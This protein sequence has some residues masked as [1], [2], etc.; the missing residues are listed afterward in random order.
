[1]SRDLRALF[2]PRSLA[3]VGASADPTKWGNVLARGALAGA[4]RRPVYLV[5]RSGGEILGQRAL[6]SLDDVPEPPELVVVSVPT[7][8][9]EDAVDAALAAGARAIVVV[10]AGLGETGADAKAREHA[11]VERVRAAGAVMLGPNC[12]GVFDAAQELDLGWSELP[13]GPIG[14]VSQSGNLALEL[15]RLATDAGL[16]FSRFASIGNQADL[17][18]ADLLD[19]LAV[20]EET[21]LVALYLEDFR[22]GRAFVA[23]AARARAAGKPVL[24]LTGGVTGASARAAL[25]HTG[26]LV[27]DARAVEAACRAAGIVAVTTPSRLIDAAQALLPARPVAGPRVAVFGDGGGHGVVAV[28]VLAARGLEVAPLSAPLRQRLGALLPPR[29]TLANPVDL[30]GGGERDLANYARIGDE[31]LGADEVDA[32]LLTGYFGGYSV[33]T[34]ALADEEAHAARLLADAAARTGKALVVHTMYPLAP[35]AAVL[36]S[37]AVP[38]YGDIERAAEAL[39]LLHRQ[40]HAGPAERST[41]RRALPDLPR[42]VAGYSGA[43]A[44]L[45]AA[46]VEVVEARE[47]HTLD[48]GLA[49]AAALGFPVVLKAVDVLH[50]SDSGG[51]ALGLDDPESLTRAFATIRARHPDSALSVERFAPVGDGVELI[52]GAIRDPR[53]GPIALVGI[54]GIYAEI[55][56]DTAVALAPVEEDAAEALIRSLRGAPLLTGA[57]GRA[58]LDLIAAAR[59]VAAISGVAAACENI[60]QIEANPLLVTPAGALA[61]DA[62]IVLRGV[63]SPA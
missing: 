18:A 50:K 8:G 10:S 38:T 23:A 54:G 55:L 17:V 2:A 39:A 41:G 30:A 25:S 63:E 36:R 29:A 9:F 31:L 60:E 47:A 33:D 7:A 21:R 16:G 56:R 62:R 5:N 14:L 53:F 44:L 1:M 22:D 15:A 52:A 61:L 32:A 43:R 28:D 59:A 6:R 20:H 11:V 13:P 34:P 4:H 12:L 40:R 27:S 49:A 42:P 51:V 57:R 3:I 19:A 48:E 26:A 45:R 37:R 46:G 58:K 24:L 35:V